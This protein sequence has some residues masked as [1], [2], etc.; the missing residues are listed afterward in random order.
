MAELLD[1]MYEI[2]PCEP[3]QDGVR[4]GDSPKSQ[5]FLRDTGE[6]SHRMERCIAS[7][8]AQTNSDRNN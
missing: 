2:R 4:F 8:Y 7:I 6:R 3:G 5:I 1:E